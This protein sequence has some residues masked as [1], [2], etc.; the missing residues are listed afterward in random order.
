MLCLEK[1]LTALLCMALALAAAVPLTADP[2]P[3]S[4]SGGTLTL[5]AD[6]PTIALTGERLVFDLQ[7]ARMNVTATLQF[8]NRGD[9]CTV[10]MG[11]PVLAQPA[12]KVGGYFTVHDFVVKVDDQPLDTTE[13]KAPMQL[14]KGEQACKWYTFSVPFEANQQRLMEVVYEERGRG[15]GT[16]I[17]IPYILATGAA[18]R[19]KIRS[20]EVVV[21]FG[22]LLNYRD[23]QLAGDGQR[24]ATEFGE[25]AMVWKTTDYDG[26]PELL[27]LTAKL[28]QRIHFDKVGDYPPRMH[29][30]AIDNVRWHNG[31]LLFAADLV[32]QMALVQVATRH[33][34]MVRFEKEGRTADLECHELPCF[35]ATEPR[36]FVDAQHAAQALGI[37]VSLPTVDIETAPASVGSARQTALHPTQLEKHRLRSLRFLATHDL[38]ACAEVCAEIGQGE[39][40]PAAL[41]RWALLYLTGVSP[42]TADL[43]DVVSR[44][45]AAG[46]E[47]LV[48]V[49][50]EMVLA[51]DCDEIV[52][53]GALV[54]RQLGSGAGRSALVWNISECENWQ[55]ATGRARN[56]GLA[57]RRMYAFGAVAALI[58]AVNSYEGK[59]KSE[60]ALVALGYLGDDEAISFLTE[61]ALR[62]D[63]TTDLIC[64][65]A[66]AL[67][68]LGTQKG[69]EA[70]ADLA[71]RASDYRA[72]GYALR[73]IEAAIS[74]YYRSRSRPRSRP[75]PDW[76]PCLPVRDACRVAIP[77]LEGIATNS[78]DK[79]TVITAER[80]L[81]S[82]RRKLAKQG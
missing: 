30:E 17:S 73:G 38:A 20:L 11:F 19:G 61:T 68:Q 67:A 71:L 4:Y 80:L 1:H 21:R 48:R 69:L 26:K 74:P 76:A 81:D 34:N 42:D 65:A 75:L 33:G 72:R 24:L 18:W 43:A 50:A 2:N 6:H 54:L 78:A 49:V 7:Q 56:A 57:L 77:L 58:E 60:D 53:G 37:V 46:D 27:W 28:G 25:G 36:L 63:A 31:R 3:V 41:R 29:S 45:E 64:C 22:D 66:R 12:P 16:D 40:Q 13:T 52:Q 14:G 9:A 51:A 70:C 59:Q 8:H 15:N 32:Q 5:M 79:A 10:Q 55:D 44:L 23:L 35:Y 47:D 62:T 82:A 39:Q